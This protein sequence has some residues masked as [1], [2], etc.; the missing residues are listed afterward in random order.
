MCHN[1]GRALL[2]YHSS[3][4]LLPLEETQVIMSG[5][6][7]WIP[8]ET[9]YCSKNKNVGEGEGA[10]NLCANCPLFKKRNKV[11]NKCVCVFLK[12]ISC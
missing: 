1:S 9:G 6:Q 4:D 3:T 8:Q 12:R 11:F 7:G 5:L 10:I 2:I